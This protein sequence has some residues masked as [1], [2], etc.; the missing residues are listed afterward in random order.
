[1][2]DATLHMKSMNVLNMLDA[3]GDRSSMGCDES[4]PTQLR[5]L[6]QAW[7][8]SEHSLAHCFSLRSYC[9]TQHCPRQL[10]P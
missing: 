10:P 2:R 3:H 8:T 5:T 7:H 4:A 6:R 1:M 9:S